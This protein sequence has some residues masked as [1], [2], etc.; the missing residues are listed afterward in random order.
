M[1]TSPMPPVRL[2]AESAERAYRDA[3][4]SLLLFPASLVVSL[5]V[6]LVIAHGVGWTTLWATSY[7]AAGTPRRGGPDAGCG[8]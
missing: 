7:P 4:L 5:A 2:L 3:W 1:S 6:F 8:C